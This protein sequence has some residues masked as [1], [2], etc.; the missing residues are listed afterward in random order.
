[1]N[2]V[3]RR[4]W[5]G[6]LS[7]IAIA[8]FLPTPA[9]AVGD[10]CGTAP[11]ISATKRA[12]LSSKASE[13][14]T[15]VDEFSCQRLSDT[16]KTSTDRCVTGLCPTY[17]ST[18][19]RCCA[20]GTGGAPGTPDRPADAGSGGGSGGTGASLVLPACVSSG[21]CELDDIVQTGVNFANFLFGISGAVFLA[22]F[23]YAGFKYIWNSSNAGEISKAK[24][25]LVNAT[26]GMILIIGA[27]IL[28]NFVYQAII[29]TGGGDATENTC[30]R[31]HAGFTC[32]PLSSDSATRSREITE[33]G[34]VRNQCLASPDNVVCCPSAPTP[35]P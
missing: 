34:C 28:V 6:L 27:G 31:N 18:E 16:K 4:A 2:M 20:P 11:G 29:T 35:T 3:F 26:V 5:F 19:V 24:T 14:G 23:V 32:V 9:L 30:E 10:G 21:D 12:E 25:M 8:G 13:A 1:M 17:S 22:I 33:R 7:L 15:T